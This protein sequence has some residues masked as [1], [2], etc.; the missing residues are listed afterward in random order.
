MAATASTRFSDLS[1]A[2]SVRQVR[3]V[4]GVILFA[5]VVSHF[6]NHALGNIS[7]DAMEIGV[8]YHMLFWQFLPVAIVFYTAALTHMGLGIYALYQRRQFRWRTVEPLQL[9]LGLSIP[10]LVMAHVIGVRLGQT[11]YGHQKLY[12]QELYLFFVASNRIW[13]MTILLLIAWVHGCIGIYFWLRLKPFFTRAAPYLLAAAVLIP[14]LSLL[15][16]YQGGR[17]VEVEADDGEWRTHN[18]TRRQLGTTAEAAMLDRITGGLTAGYLGLLAL[19]LLAR[20]ARAVR[21]R[22]GGMIA[23]SYGNGKTVRV[24]KGLSVLEASLRHNVPHASV[25]GGR[26]RC[27]TCRIRII[28]DHGALPEPSQREAFVLTRVG[29]SDPS[30]RLACQLRPT[31]DLS[32]FQLFT[33]HTL[34]ANTQASTPARIGQ[35]RYLVS[36]FVDMRGSTQL[37]EKRL[38]FDT[39]F[40]VNRFLGAVSQAVI[41]NGGQPNQFV[42]DGMLALFGL[43]A[44]PQTACRQALKAAAGIARHIDELN[45]LLSHDLRQPIRFGIGIHGG[46]VIIGDIGYRDH[47]VFTALGDAVNVAAR[48]QDM[49]KTLACEAI[50]S[51]EVRRTAGLADDALP[52]QEVAIRGRDEP[53]AVR[54]VADAREL[55]ALVD[56]GERVAA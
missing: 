56:R 18:L 11:L 29:T 7:V 42:G 49:T 2:I 4:C 3:L 55:S 12:P 38:P 50:V 48:L 51:E 46:E 27:S 6:L 26:A 19:A 23:L 45:E 52:Q 33:A 21:E 20:G 22:R 44:D 5:Y 37:A 15:G 40:I 25:C 47:I 41:E 14:T 16:V 32:F 43:S 8:Y 10:A 24:P 31:S 54:V 36:L 39:V 17:S 53:M 1:R 9:V 34:S 35:E 30:I 28:G 13:T